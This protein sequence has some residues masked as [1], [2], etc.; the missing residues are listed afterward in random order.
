MLL[1]LS[2][3][4]IES[5]QAFIFYLMQ[6]SLSNINAFVIIISIGY[7]LYI[8]V[9]Q[10]EIKKDKGEIKDKQ[11][12]IKD[13]INNEKLLDVNNSPLQLLSQLKGYYYINP[14]IAISFAIVI[15]S[16]VGIPPLVGFFGKQMILSS[17][18]DKGF[19]FITFVA[20]LTSV[21]SAVYYLVIVKQIFFYKSDYRINGS[22]ENIKFNNIIINNNKITLSSNLSLVISILTLIIL[23]F[24][25]NPQ[26]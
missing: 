12:E 1:A 5:T 25:I 6:Y 3:N 15:Y 7:T 9:N 10:D 18:L 23:L 22:L 4:S 2:I 17:A 26:E 24:I 19:I 16:F 21:I 14:V 11:E 20:I 8:Y 13:N